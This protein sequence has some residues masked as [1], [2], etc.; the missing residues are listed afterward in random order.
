MTFP[1]TTLGGSLALAGCTDHAARERLGIATTMLRGG[2]L[3]F[4]A[5]ALDPKKAGATR[6]PTIR[7]THRRGGDA[8]DHRTALLCARPVEQYLRTRGVRLPPWFTVKAVRVRE[9][10]AGKPSAMNWSDASRPIARWR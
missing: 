5:I 3:R 1:L 10:N 4:N 6:K 8:C 9:P 7:Y 2:K